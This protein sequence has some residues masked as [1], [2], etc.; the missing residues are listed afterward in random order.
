VEHLVPYSTSQPTIFKT[1]DFRPVETLKLL[2]HDRPVC[3]SRAQYGNLMVTDFDAQN[4][5]EFAITNLVNLSADPEILENLASDDKFVD[6]VL[7]RV[8]VC[9]SPCMSPAHTHV[10][11]TLVV[12]D[13]RR[14]QITANL[15]LE[16]IRR[17]CK[18]SGHA[19]GQSGEIGQHE[20]YH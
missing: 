11:A 9:L 20:T 2:I 7:A 12:H 17:K 1:E 3:P 6:A 5:A 18:L 10:R 19:A 15:D 13:Q 8:T 16:S 14:S 4:I